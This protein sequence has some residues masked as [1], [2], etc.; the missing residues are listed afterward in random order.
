MSISFRTESDATRGI[1]AEKNIRAFRAIERWSLFRN[2][3]LASFSD[4]EL[5]KVLTTLV[6]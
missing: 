5:D 3:K 1:T 4:A 2:V 6:H